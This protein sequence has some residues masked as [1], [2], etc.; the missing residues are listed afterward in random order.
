[1]IY[2][3]SLGGLGLG[4]GRLGASP[5]TSGFSPQ[6]LNDLPSPSELTYKVIHYA[7]LVA[8]NRDGTLLGQAGAPKARGARGEGID[9]CERCGDE[10][11]M[12]GYRMLRTRELA[13]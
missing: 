9:G 12:G 4:Y 6:L 10:V 5:S 1:M 2:Y 8:K 13:V 11:A 7:Q 3:F